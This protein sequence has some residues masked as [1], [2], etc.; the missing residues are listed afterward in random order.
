MASFLRGGPSGGF[1]RMLSVMQHLQLPDS[2]VGWTTEVPDSPEPVETVLFLRCS[3]LRRPDLSLTLLDI[4]DLIGAHSVALGGAG[5]CCGMPFQLLG[6]L[7]ECETHMRRLAASISAFRPREVLYACAECLYFMGNVAPHV[8]DIRVRQESVLKFI[9][10]RLDR[11]ELGSLGP[12]KVT[13]HDSCG[14][15]RLCEDY[16]SPRKIVE[17]IP[18]VELV[19]MEHTR[20]DA[21]CCGGPGEMFF[22]GKGKVLREMRLAEAKR[23]GAKELATMCVGCE[24]S[25]LKCLGDRAFGVTSVVSLLGRSLGVAREHPLQPFYSSKDVE[26]ALAKCRPNIDEGPEAY[27]IDDYRAALTMMLGVRS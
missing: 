21:F 26:G 3:G 18:E 23:T 13:I 16:E 4:M 1:G 9:A 12:M 22:P 8:T 6:D 20:K 14:H 25:Y 19:E 2:Q 11:L 24:S 7:K 27:T 5:L 17:A 10:D 15:G